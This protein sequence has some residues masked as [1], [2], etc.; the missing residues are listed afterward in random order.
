MDYVF[1]NVE[2][3]DLSNNY[4]LLNNIIKMEYK[5]ILI[6][7]LVYLGIILIMTLI[8]A[9]LLSDKK[10]DITSLSFGLAIILTYVRVFVAGAGIILFCVANPIRIMIQ[11]FKLINE[12]EPSGNKIGL[13]LLIL[14]PLLVVLI[15]VLFG[16]KILKLFTY[17]I[18]KDGK[19]AHA[20]DPSTFIK[21][22]DFVKELQ[23]RGLYFEATDE[24]L[25]RKLNS[26]YQEN[27]DKHGTSDY[28]SKASIK[29]L[30]LEDEI[31]DR[32]YNDRFEDDNSY[33]CTPDEDIK[34]PGYYYNS[35]L[36]LPK[37]EDK[38]RYAAIGRYL[39]QTRG[40][41]KTNPYKEDYYIECKIFC[42]DSKIYA[43]IGLGESEI[44]DKAVEGYRKPYYIVL[45][46]EN[47]IT[48]YLKGVYYPYGSLE[49]HY[50]EVEVH[51][52]VIDG[53][54]D[55]RYPVRKVE[56]VDIDTINR[57]CRE[58]QE[59]I[60]KKSIDEYRGHIEKQNEPMSNP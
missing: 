19:D 54:K 24:G 23:Q 30:A 52:N 9:P 56:R 51:P 2:V 40:S 49:H 57:Y 48:T 1:F 42:L 37:G 53:I 59:G 36:I 3:E 35:I 58:L 20:A 8:A 11:H 18:Y 17:L 44:V 6:A 47:H 32:V 31:S 13:I 55:N 25:L 34:A 50:Y 43:L 33:R 12:V 14:L 10:K 45:A 4:D 5:L 46:E 7:V 39:Y 21:P 41:N 38:L 22:E 15:I 28:Y 27:I 16:K 60:L 29:R 26:P